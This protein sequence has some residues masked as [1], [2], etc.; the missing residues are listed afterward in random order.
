MYIL[1]AAGT[2]HLSIDVSGSPS[3]KEW[4]EKNATLVLVTP[5]TAALTPNWPN[6]PLPISVLP[7][8]ASLSEPL[9]LSYLVEKHGPEVED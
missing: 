2:V 5:L 9:Y 1:H 4:D 6:N 3:Q 8:L 7:K